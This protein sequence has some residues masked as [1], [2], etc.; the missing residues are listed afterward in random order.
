MNL[1]NMAR[2]MMS[3]RNLLNVPKY[4]FQFPHQESETHAKVLFV[5]MCSLDSLPRESST[6]SVNVS[7]DTTQKDGM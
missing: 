3:S 6:V 7:T 4:N 5:I 1:N 2:I